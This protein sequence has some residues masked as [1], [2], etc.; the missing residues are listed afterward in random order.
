VVL[1]NLLYG[2]VLFRAW[3]KKKKDRRLSTN[4]WRGKKKKK[5]VQDQVLEN[6]H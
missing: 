5:T 6:V 4:G 2:K 3:K 1:V